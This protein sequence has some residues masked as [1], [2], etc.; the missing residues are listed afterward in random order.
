MP[1]VTGKAN[2]AFLNRPDQFGNYTITVDVADDFVE[3]LKAGR[4]KAKIEEIDTEK[5]G[6]VHEADKKFKFNFRL[7]KIR[8][9]GGENDPPKVFDSNMNQLAPNVLLGNGSLVNVQY[10][11]YE[12]PDNGSMR[13]AIQLDK[14]QVLDL[15][16]YVRQDKNEFTKQDNGFVADDTGII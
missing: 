12:Y 1:V 5:K 14:V 3:V 4:V 13:K 15:V 7:K 6:E 8:G 2:W 10:S 16:P 11:T 9:D